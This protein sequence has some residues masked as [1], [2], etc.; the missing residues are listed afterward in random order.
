MPLLLGMR[1]CTPKRRKEILPF[2]LCCFSGVRNERVIK[3]LLLYSSGS[4][5]W[6]TLLCVDN[7]NINISTD[8]FS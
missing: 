5:Y 3:E 8:M 2:L 6:V 4:N 1:Y 7:C